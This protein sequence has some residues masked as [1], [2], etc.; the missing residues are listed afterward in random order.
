MRPGASVMADNAPPSRRW[1]S[2]FDVDSTFTRFGRHLHEPESVSVARGEEPLPKDPDNQEG[3]GVEYI[4]DCA[5]AEGVVP[6]IEIPPE[7]VRKP[8]G[9]RQGVPQPFPGGNR[10]GSE[11]N[12]ERVAVT[13]AEP[14]HGLQYDHEP[15]IRDGGLTSCKALARTRES[16]TPNR[17]E[18]RWL[19]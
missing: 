19:S 17:E 14:W 10:S 5:S 6:G 2:P 15:A 12:S 7:P 1:G 3:V 18:P 16:W 13:S 11:V 9:S 4:R 8:A